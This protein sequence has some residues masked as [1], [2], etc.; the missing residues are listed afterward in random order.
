MAT[1]TDRPAVVLRIRQR[2]RP[3]MDQDDVYDASHG[4][5]VVGPRRDQCEYAIVVA[6]GIV[7]GAFRIDGWQPR[8]GDDPKNPKW[9]FVGA[10]APDLQHL[11]GT[12]V[13]DMFVKG[14]ANPVLYLND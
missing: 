3:G 7:R 5:W 13:S 4:W 1:L 6:Q 10:P 11:L 8:P 14:N 9:G 12:D 2:W